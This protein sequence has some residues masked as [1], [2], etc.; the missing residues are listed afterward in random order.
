MQ[1]MIAEY[2]RAKIMERSRRGKRHAA[3]RGSVSVLCAAPYGYKYISKH[4]GGGQAQYQ[5]AFFLLQGV[6]VVG[7]ARVNTSGWRAVPWTVGT[8][9]FNLASSVLFFASIHG[10]VPF[11]ALGLPA[12]LEGW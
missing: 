4:A 9:A 12:W 5:T 1:G 11:Y 6:A 7:T 2:E 3:R 8:L 10:L